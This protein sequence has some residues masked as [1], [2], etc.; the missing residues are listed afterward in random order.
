MRSLIWL[1]PTSRKILWVL[2]ICAVGAALGATRGA[3]QSC[4]NIPG[5]G[6]QV[7]KQCFAGYDCYTSG[8]LGTCV[9]YECYGD[10]NCGVGP[11]CGET[12]A[13]G[14]LCNPHA[15]YCGTCI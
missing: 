6:P 12:C 14:Y 4:Q 8:D 10:E 13:T 1:E 9:F 15:P 2:V 7:P 11:N 3:A 5:V